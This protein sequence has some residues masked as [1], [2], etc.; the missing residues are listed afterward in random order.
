M[1]FW[2]EWLYR[3]FVTR[4]Y[5]WGKKNSFAR[6]ALPQLP[7]TARTMHQRA[8][9]R[10]RPVLI[11]ALVASLAFVPMALAT[12]RGAEVEK[13]L[14]SVVIG[15]LIIATLLTLYILPLLYPHFSR[16]GQQAG[17]DGNAEARDLEDSF[18]RAESLDF[19]HVQI[20]DE[21]EPDR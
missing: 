11:T 8:S 13:P 18:G 9:D 19:T 5:I 12:S 4:K 21:T 6:N 7:R 17:L 14:A 2:D 3:N 20:T 15:G 10:L 1:A 16:L